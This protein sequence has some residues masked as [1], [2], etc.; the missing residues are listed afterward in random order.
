MHITDTFYIPGVQQ[1]FLGGSMLYRVLLMS[2]NCLWCC[3][4]QLGSTDIRLAGLEAQRFK[5]QG[6]TTE[7]DGR[8]QRLRDQV[9]W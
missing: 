2:M 8:C 9:G 6:D 4:P 5:L 3:G 7:A 1:F